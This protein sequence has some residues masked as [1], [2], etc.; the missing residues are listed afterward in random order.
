MG[1]TSEVAPAAPPLPEESAAKHRLV[2]GALATV[3]AAAGLSAIIL[4]DMPD[5][6]LAI[7]AGFVGTAFGWAGATFTFYFGTSQGSS[8]K[9][10]LMAQAMRRLS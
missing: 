10:G 5:S 8:D 9:Q 4:V 3:L 7:V 6:K 2:F 1:E